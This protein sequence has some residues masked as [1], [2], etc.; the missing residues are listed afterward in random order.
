MHWNVFPVRVRVALD[1]TLSILTKLRRMHD[2]ERHLIWSSGKRIALFCLDKLVVLD[3][4]A[5]CFYP[6]M[7]PNSRWYNTCLSFFYI[8]RQIRALTRR[9]HPSARKETHEMNL[10][11]I[12]QYQMYI[13]TNIHSHTKKHRG[14]SSIILLPKST[15]HA[16]L[17][18]FMKHLSRRRE[19]L[20]PD[21]R[22]PHP[23]AHMI[24]VVHLDLG[25]AT[26]LVRGGT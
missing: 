2:C 25:V 19:W 13:H 12:A 22:A 6:R 11:S 4:S 26:R 5:L 3:L 15:S 10:P 24:R 8:S 7:I 20:A 9:F 14:T 16:L 23:Q 18:E 1:C 21:R 17:H